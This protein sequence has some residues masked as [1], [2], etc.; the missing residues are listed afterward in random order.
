MRCLKPKMG[1]GPILKDTPDHLPNIW[2][3]TWFA[4]PPLPLGNGGGGGG[5][6]EK[7]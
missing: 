4:P 1:T 7:G 2:M 5:G 6:G 3:F